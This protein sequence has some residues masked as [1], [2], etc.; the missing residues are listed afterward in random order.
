MAACKLELMHDAEYKGKGTGRKLHV[1]FL[2]L[3]TKTKKVPFHPIANNPVPVVAEYQYMK[4]AT[5]SGVSCGPTWA[6]SLDAEEALLPRPAS[7]A[8]LHT[9]LSHSPC[10]TPIF[11]DNSKR[12][13]RTTF[14]VWWHQYA[15]PY[16]RQGSYP[17]P[18]STTQRMCETRGHRMV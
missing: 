15:Y 8:A 14:R 13:E 1:S 5:T 7:T 12:T 4:K 3:A 6:P 9:H 18:S 10:F 17:L 2:A 11:R 16:F